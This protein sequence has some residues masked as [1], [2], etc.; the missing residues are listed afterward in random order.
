M[1]RKVTCVSIKKRSKSANYTNFRI[2]FIASMQFDR[3]AFKDN[4]PLT[5]LLHLPMFGLKRI[6]V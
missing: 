3:N 2:Y 1:M 5:L 6:L 4:G